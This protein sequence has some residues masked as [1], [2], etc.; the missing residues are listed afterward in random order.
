M[1]DSFSE[2]YKEAASASIQKTLKDIEAI[3]EG[4][5]LPSEG[6]KREQLRDKLRN[7]LINL[8]IDWLEYGFKGGHIVAAKEFIKNGY[9]P[10]TIS[11][12]I[13]RQFPVRNWR[14]N[15]NLTCQIKYWLT[16]IKM[17]NHCMQLTAESVTSFAKSR[18]SC[19]TSGVS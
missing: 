15:F 19:A 3:L 10:D 1:S 8:S 11:R 18:K 13:S 16:L 4:Y 5:H 9:F 14:L 7:E 6:V 2:I 17:P 12:K